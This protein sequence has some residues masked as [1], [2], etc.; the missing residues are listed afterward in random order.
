MIT[1]TK[2]HQPRHAPPR[3]AHLAGGLARLRVFGRAEFRQGALLRRRIPAQ[4]EGHPGAYPRGSRAWQQARRTAWTPGSAA[5]RSTS[6]C[7]IGGHRQRTTQRPVEERVTASRHTPAPGPAPVH[8]RNAKRAAKGDPISQSPL[9][10]GSRGIVFRTR[11][12]SA[13]ARL[14][15]VAEAPPRAVVAPRGVGYSG[16]D[17]G[18]C[19]TT[20]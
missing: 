14:P 9:A 18:R 1:G 10:E 4:S 13:V 19:R 5:R 2:K 3:A 17:Q 15:C 7:A 12:Q 20:N 8:P 11:T 16:E 6:S